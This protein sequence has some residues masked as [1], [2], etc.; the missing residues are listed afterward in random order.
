MH[1]YW[2][3]GD[4]ASLYARAVAVI[5]MECHSPIISLVNGTP[6]FYV[7][8]PS[9]TIKGQMYYDLQLE[10]WVFEIEETSGEDIAARLMEVYRSYSESL[11]NVTQLNQR[12]K[13]IYDKRMEEFAIKLK[14]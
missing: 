12:V 7:R 10:D 11:E 8:Q 14:E 6:A 1:P 4:A 13:S 9:D 2:Q 5:S 3:P